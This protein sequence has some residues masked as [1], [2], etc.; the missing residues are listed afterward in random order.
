MGDRIRAEEVLIAFKEKLAAEA[1]ESK[2]MEIGGACFAP[3]ILAAADAK[4]RDARQAQIDQDA[5]L[6]SMIERPRQLLK[7]VRRLHLKY[8]FKPVVTTRNMKSV[9]LN[10]AV[11]VDRVPIQKELVKIYFE[12]VEVKEVVS[13]VGLRGGSLSEDYDMNDFLEDDEIWEDKYR[14][15]DSA[16]CMDFDGIC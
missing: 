8:G 15:K 4:A 7:E 11:E 16:I 14:R 6:R 9:V 3:Y 12:H 13:T 5:Q 1:R 10:E 2:A